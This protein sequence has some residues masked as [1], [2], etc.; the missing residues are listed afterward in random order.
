VPRFLADINAK[1]A[2]VIR[3]ILVTTA[4][5][6][7]LPSSARAV[8]RNVL[9]YTSPAAAIAAAQDGDR[10]YFPSPGPYQAPANGWQITKSLEIFGDGVGNG[11]RTAGSTLLAR[12]GAGNHIFNIDASSA[13][14]S[15]IYVHDLLLCG[16]DTAAGDGIHAVITSGSNTITG[17]S[18]DR[19]QFQKR[20][21]DGLHIDGGANNAILIVRIAD[22]IANGCDS[23][24][25]DLRRCT[26]TYVLGGYF[27]SCK[28]FGIYAEAAY[29]LRIVGAALEQNQ[30]S[31]ASNDYD[32]Q[33][34][35]KLC[36]PFTVLGCHF[37]EFN[38]TTSKTA[39]SVEN[40][41]GGEI[42]TSLF[43]KNTAGV[44]GLRGIFINGGSQNI[45]VG[46]NT[47]TY[48]DTLVSIK[49]NDSNV[50]CLVSQQNP[51]S[52]DA[53]ARAIVS[54]PDA[55]Q[56][57]NFA[58]LPTTKT[59]GTGAGLLLPRVTA[60]IRDSIPSDIRQRGILLFNSTDNQF[61]T[62]DGSRWGMVVDR[63]GAADLANQTGN[64]AS[65]NV[66]T[67]GA[68]GVYR[69]SIYLRI[70]TTA[71]GTMTVRIGWNDSVAKTK[72]II[73]LDQ[74]IAN[75]EADGI[76]T[77]YLSGS[78]NITYQTLNVN[79]LTHYML[80]VRAEAL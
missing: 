32:S 61:N 30:S 27:Q 11:S 70:I 62:Y 21:N 12:T 80:R 58:F 9:D 51:F 49:P 79:A 69:V 72:D 77:L 36:H 35:L 31:G 45:T 78:Q 6:A 22:C 63:V 52:T 47:W 39:I 5:L 33:L 64:V 26:T 71:V 7:L 10:I 13:S 14:L 73:S 67:G 54:L 56:N 44:T 76:V 55:D 8:L 17:L 29:G 24:G 40:C 65:T 42:A 60:V 66:V 46:S 43:I 50:G 48:I 20:L 74:S 4:L 41:R 34:R 59:S 53:N 18:F 19:L 38:N 23:T 37:E 16:P 75:N 57:G 28:H 15:H 2:A 1:E 3:Q 25:L 68:A